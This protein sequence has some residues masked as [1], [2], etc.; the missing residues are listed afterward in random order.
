MDTKRRPLIVSTVDGGHKR[1]RCNKKKLERRP[2]PS[3][4]LN[5]RYWDIVRAKRESTIAVGKKPRLAIA[6]DPAETKKSPRS[7]RGSLAEN[8]LASPTVISPL[9]LRA[10]APFVPFPF[11]SF[12][13][14][15]F[16]GGTS[17]YGSIGDV[18][19][20]DGGAAFLPSLIE[21]SKPVPP[22]PQPSTSRPPTE[23]MSIAVARKTTPS[24]RDVDRLADSIVQSK[25]E[26]RKDTNVSGHSAERRS[27]Q[28]IGRLC[29]VPV[30]VPIVLPLP[31]TTDFIVRHFSLENA[32]KILSP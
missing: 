25:L 1:R 32:M 23:P 18:C 2:H 4:I 26:G 30:P 29:I 3:H 12:P 27:S 9:L 19:R 22:L 17:N 21:P 13:T 8:R 31:L 10:N 5:K 15:P 24:D 16:G 7:S 14:I 11:L 6:N 20:G 28:V